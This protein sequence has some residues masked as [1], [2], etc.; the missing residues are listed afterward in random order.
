MN[1]NDE[2]LHLLDAAV[3]KFN[4]VTG[5]LNVSESQPCVTISSRIPRE[6][7]LV[8]NVQPLMQSFDHSKT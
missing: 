1:R 6:Q 5:G 7:T 4:C 2:S 8:R 3:R